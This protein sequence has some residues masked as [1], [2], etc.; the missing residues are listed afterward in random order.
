MDAA[1]GQ[2]LKIFVH[3]FHEKAFVVLHRNLAL[4]KLYVKNLS[5]SS[6]IMF[7]NIQLKINSQYVSHN[8]TCLVDALV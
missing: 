2:T 6:I 8:A 3:A 5:M 1:Q 4:S 7:F